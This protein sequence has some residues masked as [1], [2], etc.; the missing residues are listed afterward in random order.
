MKRF[1]IY[2]TEAE[3]FIYDDKAQTKKHIEYADDSW[4]ALESYVIRTYNPRM[5]EF[6]YD[7]LRAVEM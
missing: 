2:D 7:V 6:A 5:W 4:S 1:F 3:F